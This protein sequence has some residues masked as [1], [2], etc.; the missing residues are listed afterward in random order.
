MHTPE[1]FEKR[2][3]CKYLD[4]VHCWYCKPG[5]HGFGK[6]GVPDI[7]GCWFGKFIGIE[8]KRPGKAPTERQWGI[9]NAIA[10]R[11]GIAVWGTAK[12]II[13]SL[14]QAGVK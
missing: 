13:A 4:S 9:L 6:S 14:M 11:G 5:T 10:D 3:V 2:D 7:V 12:D 8:V 1:W